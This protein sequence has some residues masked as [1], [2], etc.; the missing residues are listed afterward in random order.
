MMCSPKRSPSTER[1]TI[2]PQ[3]LDIPWAPVPTS[4]TVTATDAEQA[5]VLW[6][7]SMPDYEGLLDATPE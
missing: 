4:V 1:A 3:P 5:G 6:D 7:A 2:K